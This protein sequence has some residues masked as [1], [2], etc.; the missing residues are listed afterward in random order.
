MGNDIKSAINEKLSELARKNLELQ[1]E[2]EKANKRAE[3]ILDEALCEFLTVLDTFERAEQYIAE[4]ELDKDEDGS[5]ATKRLLNA[6]KKAMFVLEKYNVKKMVFENNMSI[7]D[8][9]SV[10]DTEPDS[11][12]QNGEIVSIE[13]NGYL[14]DD[15]LLRSAEVIIIKN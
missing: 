3:S 2:C 1:S 13:K 9:C 14:R 11:S 5:K 7:P 6:K 8:W 4:H 12:R 15:R 10:T